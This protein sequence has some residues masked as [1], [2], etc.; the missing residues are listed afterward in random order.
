VVPA[1]GTQTSGTL[2]EIHQGT[3]DNEYLNG[4]DPSHGFV[5]VCGKDAS[6]RAVLYRFGFNTMGVMSSSNSGG[7]LALTASGTGDCSPLAEVFNPN[8]GTVGTGTD[9]LF[10]GIPNNCAFGTHTEGC[11]MS[12]NITG[13]DITPSTMPTAAFATGSSTGGTSGI[14]VD[15]ISTDGRASSLYFTTLGTP[16]CS[17]PTSTST[18]CAVQFTQAG[19]Q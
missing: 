4:P 10:V 1:I 14:V 13:T 7:P 5:Y 6:G 2:A 19:L 17:N 12:F 15:N 16:G 18:A 9:W 8:Q 11:V 3:F